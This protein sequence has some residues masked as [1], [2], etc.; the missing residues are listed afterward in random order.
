MAVATGSLARVNILMVLIGYGELQVPLYWELLDNQGGN[1]TSESRIDLLE[2]CFAIVDRKRISIVI[3][4]RKFVG[5]KWI[6]FLKEN[7]LNVVIR[8]PK[9]HA[10]TDSHQQVRCIEELGLARIV[11]CELIRS[12]VVGVMYG[13]NASM[14]PSICI[15]LVVSKG[16]VSGSGI[17]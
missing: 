15:Y 6:K 11:V 5:H 8:F 14:S 4:G 17:L 7:R 13:A 16:S 2:K 3:G 10:L 9:H 12:M 1:S